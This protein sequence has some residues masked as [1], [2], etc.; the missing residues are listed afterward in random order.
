MLVVLLFGFSSGL[1]IMILY[2]S[3]KIW[4]RREGIDLSAIG[5]MSWL[6]IP[7][8]F[9]FIWA[10][11]LDRYTPHKFGRRKSWILL[12]QIGLIFSFILLSL[13]NPQSNI[14]FIVAAGFLLCFFSATQDISIDAYRAE[15]LPESELGV[16]SSIGVYGYRVGMLAASGFGLWVVD[17]D[18]LNFTFNQMFLL[19]AGFM[20]IG[21]IGTFI[22][23]EPEVD[24]TPPG[25]L[26]ESVYIPFKDFLTRD[27]A[28]WTLAFI[29][30]FKMGDAIAGSMLGPYY[31]DMGFSNK[32]I[33]EIT[34]G[35]GFFS[36]MAGLFVGGTVIFKI[37]IY[38]S[39]WL[40][41]FLQACSTG[42]ISLLALYKTKFMLT[43]VVAFEDFSSGMG[44]TAMVAFMAGIANKRF[45]ATQY[46]LFASLASFGRTF[47]SGFSGDIIKA[48]GYFHFFI[49]C[50]VLAL[51]G[52][53]LLTKMKHV[54]KT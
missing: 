15:I 43:I 22:A 30:M 31:V 26:I 8:S 48:L 2:S 41:G 4:L 39:M 21:L 27:Y 16:G 37:G 9:N 7:Y 29:L 53:V 50:A 5:Y 12:L 42:V 38:R 44:T 1:P 46:A 33:A 14:M 6:T 23:H 32:T 13:G 49:F 25:S 18:T 52:L 20:S 19:M 11:L 40:F 3:I 36:S 45:T 10:F 54:Q 47:F 17:P 51:P 35:I 34:K 28:L 24:T